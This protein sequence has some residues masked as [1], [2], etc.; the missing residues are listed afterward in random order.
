MAQNFF[1]SQKAVF[2]RIKGIE[3]NYDGAN[4]LYSAPFKLLDRPL[5][6]NSTQYSE[7]STEQSSV[8]IN[9]YETMLL[10]RSCNFPLSLVTLCVIKA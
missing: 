4:T 9:S 6:L 3:I 8:R 2:S 7:H 1:L 10:R 5:L